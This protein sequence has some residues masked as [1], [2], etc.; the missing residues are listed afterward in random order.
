M[1]LGDLEAFSRA[2]NDHD[3]DALMSYMTDDCVF[4][5][6]G[7]ADAY[8]SR[9]EGLREVRERFESVW[10]DLPD[11][12]FEN[13]RHF[14]SG[15]RGC[16]EWTLVATRPDGSKLEVDGCDLFEFEGNLISVKNTFL[17]NRNQ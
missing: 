1:K 5:S 16:S 11:V 4:F 7:G 14:V 15:N 6:G 10:K 2:W 13:A 12:S 17:K 8:G 9:Y 3:I